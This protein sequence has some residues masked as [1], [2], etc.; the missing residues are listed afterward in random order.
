MDITLLPL[1]LI[2]LGERRRALDGEKVADLA[3]SIEGQG[4]FQAIGVRPCSSASDD[5][6][7]V[8]G[9]HRLEAYKL[10]HRTH[11][12]AYVLP[13][14]LLPEEYLLIELQEN[15][16]RN[17]LSGVQRKAYAADVGKLFA[18]IADQRHTANGGKNWFAEL[19]K[20]AGVPERTLLNW[21]KTFCEED[22]YDLT[23][24][25]AAEIHRTQFFA[26]LDQQKA[27]EEAAQ[28][29]RREDIRQEKQ[30]RDFVDAKETLEG[31]IQDYGREAVFYG[32][33]CAVFPTLDP[34]GVPG[35]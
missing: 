23:P 10:L 35:S 19:A 3:K 33:V 13:A 6:E 8:F 16:V 17:D 5:F 32:V 9:A 29:Q 26:W 15:S 34:L 18:K 31:L 27:N 2:R 1:Y 12:D 7:V 20:T 21:W 25:Q 4:L 14:D 28:A 24:R 11:I 22:G 30:V